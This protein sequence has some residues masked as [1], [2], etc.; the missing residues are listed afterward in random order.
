MA[1]LLAL[2]RH[3]PMDNAIWLLEYVAET[4]GAEHLK[5]A[6]RHLNTMQ[7]LSLDVIGFMALVAYIVTK[8]VRKLRHGKQQRRVHCNGGEK[9]KGE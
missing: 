6:S 1:D 5:P 8:F 2:E 7:Y 4:R 3:D 9:V